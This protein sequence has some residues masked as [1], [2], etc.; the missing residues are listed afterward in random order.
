VSPLDAAGRAAVARAKRQPLGGAS[1]DG[2]GPGE[3]ARLRL[4]LDDASVDAF[5]TANVIA[6]L[7]TASGGLISLA[8]IRNPRRSVAAAEC[9][10][11]A[12]CGAS[13]DVARTRP[14]ELFNRTLTEHPR[15]GTK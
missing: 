2:V 14:A 3:R 9:P 4:S 6:A 11:G 7:L 8:G 10:G 5:R 13:E 15:V 1:L 12:L